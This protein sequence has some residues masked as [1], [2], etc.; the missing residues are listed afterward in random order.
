MSLRVDRQKCIDILK[1]LNDLLPNNDGDRDVTALCLNENMKLSNFYGTDTSDNDEQQ[2]KVIPHCHKLRL[3]EYQLDYDSKKNWVASERSRDMR[4]IFR[5]VRCYSKGQHLLDNGIHI[6]NSIE[7][8]QSWIESPTKIVVHGYFHTTNFECDSSYLQFVYNEK[9]GI[10]IYDN[11][12]D[13]DCD[14][15]GVVTILDFSKYFRT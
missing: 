15:D 12:G 3:I 2:A 9:Y 5:A 4:M 6:S 13:G 10:W 8:Y 1:Q 7:F 14:E 11:D